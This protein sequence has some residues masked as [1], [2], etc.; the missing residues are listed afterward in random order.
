MLLIAVNTILL[1][2]K[3]LNEAVRQ[4]GSSF[5]EIINLIDL[6][7]S[8]SWRKLTGSIFDP[9]GPVLKKKELF[10]LNQLEKA[11]LH[12]TPINRTVPPCL[13]NLLNG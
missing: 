2:A 5:Q 7:F 9:N 1:I 11:S 13:R 3:S 6:F 4:Q 8:P 12:T 10:S